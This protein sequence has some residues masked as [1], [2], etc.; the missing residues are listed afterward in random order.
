MYLLPGVLLDTPEEG[1]ER[2]SESEK[3]SVHIT[4]AYL[5]ALL[6][7]VYI[8]ISHT[9]L[10]FLARE[11]SRWKIIDINAINAH[12]IFLY[13]VDTLSLTVKNIALDEREA[14]ESPRDLVSQF[15]REAT[16]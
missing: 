12:R 13:H 9:F 7:H 1:E 2:M 3:Y 11:R 15:S 5:I 4:T 8:Y 16:R 14:S 6:C 10:E